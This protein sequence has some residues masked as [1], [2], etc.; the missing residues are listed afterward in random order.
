MTNDKPEFEPLTLSQIHEATKERIDYISKEFTR[1]FEFIEGH[2]RSVTFF[3]SA[4]LPETDPHYKQAEAV[5]KRI[6]DELGYSV[7]SGGGP[8]IMEAANRG[9]K[10][11][12][13][14]SLGLAIKLPKEQETNPY[15]TDAL[16]FKY[17]FSR[18]VCM[19]FAAEAYL[20]FP[21][22]FGT[23]DEFFEILTLVQT[24]KIES[25][26]VILVGKDFWGPLNDFIINTLLRQGTISPEDIDLYT[27]TDDIDE[28]LDIIKKAPVR[29]SLL[30]DKE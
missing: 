11:A 15:V 23:M 28:I 7:L 24:H 22:G 19:S 30:H 18:K 26:P 25:V 10:D 4:R 1:G 5:A 16:E 20:F 2:P 8:G 27:L 9:A 14:H 3:G 29:D 13:G 21:G 6:V 17:F 12:G